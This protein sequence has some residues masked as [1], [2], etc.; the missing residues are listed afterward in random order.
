MIYYLFILL[1]LVLSFF[2]SMF[3]YNRLRPVFFFLA[4]GLFV[5]IQCYNTW[6]PDMMSY[7]IHF[8]YSD[9]DYV[10]F[11]LEPIH[12]YLIEFVKYINGS[13]ED[14][15]MIYGLLI[16]GFLLI[17]IKKYTPYPVFLLCIFFIIPFFPN[18]TQLRFF[19]AFSI[20]LYSLQFYKTNK[21]LFYGLFVVSVLCHFSM[22][23]ILVFFV[24][25]N[26]AF[27][28]NQK[29]SNVII[30]IALGLLSLIPKQI[31]EP[32][33]TFLNPKYSMYL[34]ATSTF[35]GTIVLFASFFALNN[36]VI[37]HYRNHFPKIEHRIEDKYKRHIPFFIKLIQYSNYLILAQY[38]IRDFSRITMNLSILS[39]IYLSV[40]IFY[41][42]DVKQK[43]SN[44]I[45]LR[46]SLFIWAVITFYITFLM[47]NEGDYMVSVL[48]TF[49]SNS[50]YGEIK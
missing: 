14:F 25:K 47:L 46:F 33:V 10:R 44:V 3:K 1:L 2:E 5:I 12:L 4:S 39:Y 22:L 42:V 15:I 34:E 48:R 6:S 17:S 26:M 21:K 16:M 28:N 20:F 30:L 13:F 8:K 18:I 36:F 7:E 29:K 41:G 32:I 40:V 11:G 27:F 37:Y 38:F 19:L 35:I 50:V 43:M 24:I 31:S 9:E 49:T 23:I 45:S